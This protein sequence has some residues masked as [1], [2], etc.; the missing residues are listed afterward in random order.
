MAEQ[1]ASVVVQFEYWELSWELARVLV[2]ALLVMLGWFYVSR[3]NNRRETRKENRQFLDRTIMLLEEIEGDSVSYFL[4]ASQAEAQR[5]SS[6]I[7]P[8]LMRVEKAL[9]HLNLPGEHGSS[10]NAIAVSEK[11]TGHN[12]WLAAKKVALAPDCATI[13]QVN[14]AF[15]ELIAALEAAYAKTFQK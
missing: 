10:I 8:A 11:V 13:Y 14:V 15:A 4:T 9:S 5:L 3:D 12:A 6:K 7:G 1:A 2:P